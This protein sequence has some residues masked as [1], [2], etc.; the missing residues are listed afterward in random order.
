MTKYVLASHCVTKTPK[1][2]V[3]AFRDTD[4]NWRFCYGVSDSLPGTWRGFRSKRDF[5]TFYPDPRHFL[6]DSFEDRSNYNEIHDFSKMNKYQQRKY[7][8]EYAFVPQSIINTSSEDE[9]EAEEIDDFRGLCAEKFLA[10]P[11]RHTRRQGFRVTNR[12]DDFTPGQEY[13][14]HWIDIEREYRSIYSKGEHLVTF[15]KGERPWKKARPRSFMINLEEMP[16]IQQAS[17]AGVDWAVSEQGNPYCLEIN[18][19]P[20]LSP[21]NIQRVIERFK[22]V[23]TED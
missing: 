10:R 14:S 11:L 19:A 15:L 9:D 18:L 16:V 3:N 23:S 13:I 22:S 17:V 21:R 7:I 2:I 5:F 12:W 4:A 1:L 8:K 6:F 20:G